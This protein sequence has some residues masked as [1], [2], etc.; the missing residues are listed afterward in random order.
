MDSTYEKLKEHIICNICNE[1]YNEKE[2][3]PLVFNCGH[4]FCKACVTEILKSQ[5]K[6]CSVCK[7]ALEYQGIN[8]VKKNF[9]L[10]PLVS[11]IR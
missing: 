8:N 5:N 2:R 7:I 11:I 6:K 9:E 4:G 10:I 3:E 1:E